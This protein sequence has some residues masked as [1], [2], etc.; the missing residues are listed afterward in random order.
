MR[1][2]GEGRW[3]QAAGSLPQI[4]IA[5]ELLSVPGDIKVDSGNLSATL[6]APDRLEGQ[7]WL[8]STQADKPAL[9]QR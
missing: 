3:L 1:Y 4:D 8:N 7:R 5:I 9:L 2:R 6:I